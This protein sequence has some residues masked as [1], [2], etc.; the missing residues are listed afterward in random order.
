MHTPTEYSNSRYRLATVWSRTVRQ[1][2]LRGTPP[3]E[4]QGPR[5]QERA[6]CVQRWVCLVCAEV[7]MLRASVGGGGQANKGQARKTTRWQGRRVTM[8]YRGTGGRTVGRACHAVHGCGGGDG[9]AR[10]RLPERLLRGRHGR[11]PHGRLVVVVAHQ[12]VLA[13]ELEH[14]LRASQW[15]PHR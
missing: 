9:A 8:N 15:F 3:C 11:L 10:G 12:E 6:W 4:G 1:T 14:V 2:S 7:G 13:P 5:T